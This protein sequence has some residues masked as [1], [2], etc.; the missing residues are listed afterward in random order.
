MQ[1]LESQIAAA[2]IGL[3]CDKILQC[4]H[5]ARVREAKNER[6]LTLKDEE[7]KSLRSQLEVVQS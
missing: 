3:D 6:L 7:N 1:E 2:E 5:A 4:L